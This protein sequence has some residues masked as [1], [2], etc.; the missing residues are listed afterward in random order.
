MV[1]A[2]TVALIWRPDSELWRVSHP[3][4][5][6][7]LR[8]PSLHYPAV[9]W[10]PITPAALS[11]SPFPFLLLFHYLSLLL[12]LWFSLSPGRCFQELPVSPGW[13]KQT[14]TLFWYLIQLCSFSSHRPWSTQSIRCPGS[15]S[16]PPVTDLRFQTLWT[17]TYGGQRVNKV[18]LHSSLAH[19]TTGFSIKLFFIPHPSMN[20]A[21]HV[22]VHAPLSRTIEAVIW[23]QNSEMKVRVSELTLLV[24]V[25]T[26]GL[27]RKDCCLLFY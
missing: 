4:R 11:V 27:L 22:L 25:L 26:G 23:V 5:L 1:E 9:A 13:L 2:I 14:L 21:L 7:P 20:P 10:G 12:S 8:P 15:H 17:I 24:R 16:P 18:V 6:L 3:H 19:V